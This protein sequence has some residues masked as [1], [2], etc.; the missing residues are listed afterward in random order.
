MKAIPKPIAVHGVCR[1]AAY[2]QVISSIVMHASTSSLARGAAVFGLS[3]TDKARESTDVRFG[4]G[5]AILA[6]S[7]LVDPSTAS[8]R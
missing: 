1:G 6:H 3:Q 2:R 5:R 8:R 4:T 7:D